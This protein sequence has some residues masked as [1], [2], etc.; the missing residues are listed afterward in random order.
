MSALEILK[1]KDIICDVLR[2]VEIFPISEQIADIIS[3]YDVAFF[4]EEAYDYGSISEK[5]AAVC[6]NVAPFTIDYFVKHG[7]S[8]V[9]IDELGFSAQKMAQQIEDFLSDEQT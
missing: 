1:T 8:D 7:D 3:S 5:Y 6:D 4:F 2:L 9:L